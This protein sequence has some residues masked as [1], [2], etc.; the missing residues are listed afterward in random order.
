MYIVRMNI[1]LRIL[2]FLLL[3]CISA[4]AADNIRISDIRTLSLGGSSATETPL[5]NPAVLSAQKNKKVYAGYYNR[6]S[7]KE[8]ATVSGGVYYTNDVLP[9]GF[10]IY[11]FGYDEYRESLFRLSM[12]KQIAQKWSLGVA[13]QYTLLQSELFE[14][15]SGIVST[16]IGV[17]YKPSE[18]V[19]T[20]LSILNFPS[21]KTG[22]ENID[23]SHIAP[24]AVLLG[25]N[26]H[27]TEMVLLTGSFEHSKEESATGSLGMEYLAFENFKIRA[28]T[29]VSPLSPT[30][31]VGYNINNIVADVSA[32]YHSVLGISLGIGLSFLF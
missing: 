17:T 7:V 5:Y 26:W 24:Y 32:V 27:F 3:I 19:L 8:L 28:G 16:D 11:S 6:Y 1:T 25:V 13:F 30:L 31:G 10:E 20:G 2:L 22:D 15:S 21:V 9:T 14:E 12:G 18:S 23:N 4:N 29:K